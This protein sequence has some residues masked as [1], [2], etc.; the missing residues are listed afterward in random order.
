MVV[1]TTVRGAAVDADGDTPVC[2]LWVRPDSEREHPPGVVVVGRLA[3]DLAVDI[4][5]GV[6]GDHDR[7]PAPSAIAAAFS[8][9]SR[10]T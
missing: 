9:D 10:R 8:I 7:R 5:G 2:T 6:G 4:D 3:E 1:T